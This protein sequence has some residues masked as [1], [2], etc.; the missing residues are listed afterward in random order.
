D[1]EHDGPRL[2][3]GEIAFFIGRN[4]SER[5]K[6][7]MRRFLHLTE[8]NKTNVVKLAHFFE[9][10][11]N[12]HVARLS[13]A[14]IGRP[15]KGGYGGGHWNGHGDFSFLPNILL[16]VKY[17][18]HPQRRPQFKTELGNCGRMIVQRSVDCLDALRL[19]ALEM[20]L[21]FLQPFGGVALPLRDLA[22]DPKRLA[23]AVGLSWI[24]REFLVRQV[25]VVKDRAGRL[26]V[27]P[28]PSVAGG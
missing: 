1:M 13:L 21:H 3:Q 2:E 10:P 11:A 20:V 23:R 5:M 4:L 9:R 16:W 19:Q 14:A 15:F 28:F 6:R 25:G 22:R 27:D 26:H 24:A 17:L 18:S 7:S 8:R 12:A